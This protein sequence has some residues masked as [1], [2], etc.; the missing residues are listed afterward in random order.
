MYYNIVYLTLGG[1]KFLGQLMT[2]GLDNLEKEY[3]DTY[4]RNHVAWMEREDMFFYNEKINMSGSHVFTFREI[5]KLENLIFINTMHEASCNKI[6][7]RNQYVPTAMENSDVK[8]I[9]IK[10]H[11]ECYGFLKSNNIDFFDFDFQ[12]F[13]NREHFL[14]S[15]HELGKHFDINFDTEV[16]KYAHKKWSNANL[17][18][19][20]DYNKANK[21]T[22]IGRS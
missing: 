6:E 21:I 13:W 20:N 3:F 2:V 14:K 17:R 8:N 9:R 11:N 19:W 15:M 12:N 10:Y 22:K 4:D 5:A 18:G 7:Q 16:L 1:G